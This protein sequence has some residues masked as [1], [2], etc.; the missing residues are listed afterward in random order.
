[1]FRDFGRWRGETVVV[2][3][4]GESMTPADAAY[5]RARARVIT[6]NTTF[7]LA[8]WA[9]AHYS[10][11]ADWWLAH[12]DEMRG[13]CFGE[14]WTGHPGAPI[15]EDIR[16]CAY[17]KRARGLVETPG[18]IAWGGNSGYC[19]I[20]LAYQL[21][22][23]RIVLV[24]FDQQGGHWHPDHPEAVRKPPNWPMWR[25]RFGEM[26]A[27]CRRLGVEV[28]NSTRSTALDCFPLVRLREALC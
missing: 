13:S 10:S 16:V 28:L 1:M 7:R 3:A 20:G 19:A 21:G 27:D 6:V 26:A 22:A 9:D 15:A 5:C 2:L 11:D 14:F 4:S 12:L 18:R 24:G 25:E 23:R 8:P 17:D